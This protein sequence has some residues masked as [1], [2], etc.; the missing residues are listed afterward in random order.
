M[1]T[2]T[3]LRMFRP[4]SA[5]MVEYGASAIAPVTVFLLLSQVGF[6]SIL[7]RHPVH[8]KYALIPPGRWMDLRGILLKYQ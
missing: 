6:H 8:S 5:A 4:S 3:S 1:L 7:L 2:Q